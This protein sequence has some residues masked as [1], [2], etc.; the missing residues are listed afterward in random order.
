MKTTISILLFCLS[1]SAVAQ[2]Y[3]CV[4]SGKTTYSELP[5]DVNAKIVENRVSSSSGAASSISLIRD[6]TGRFS[7]Q[8]SINGKSTIFTVDTGATF[9]TI[10]GDFAS[11]LGIHSCVPVGISHTANGDT[12]TCRVAVSSLSVGGF[13]YSNIYIFLNPTMQGGAL[14]GN[15]ILSGLKVSQ[16]GNVMVLSR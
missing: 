11:K 3:K 4:Q 14:L 5:C 7:L 16:Q 9:T 8:G 10:S 2:T 1:H 6:S 12:P 13:N 15:D